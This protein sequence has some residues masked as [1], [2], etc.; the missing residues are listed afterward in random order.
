MGEAISVADA[1]DMWISDLQLRDRANT[2]RTYASALKPLR[3]LGY[4]HE[5]N[6]MVCRE[7]AAD[8]QR[9]G[10]TP[11]T[12]RAFVATMQSFGNYCVERGWLRESFAAGVP[13]PRKV[14]V[15]RRYLTPEQARRVY[16]C[17]RDDYDR[18][19][20]LLMA[21]SGLRRAEVVRLRLRDFDFARG[22]VMI[23]AKGP[24]WNTVA[25]DAR[26][27][28]MVRTI[29]PRRADLIFRFGPNQ[30]WVRVRNM[31][32][33]AGVPLAPHMLRHLA[34]Q[35]FLE[36]G[37]DAFSLQSML[38]HASIDTTSIYVEDQQA[39]ISLQ[40]QREIDLGSRL[41]GEQRSRP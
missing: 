39:A 5:L 9:G 8:R 32:Y 14:R 21:G 30:L 38:G 28:E 18:L 11:N 29:K 40:R 34:A 25:I 41:F 4:L 23:Y 27:S 33:R 37:G 36:A 2:A 15:P 12:L 16:E 26:V 17:A 20:L 3:G 22:T 35:Q 19:A 1:L 13:K 6:P 7:L 10:M 31:G 24:K